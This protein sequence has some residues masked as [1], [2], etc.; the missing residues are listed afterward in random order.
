M[1]SF[2]I[3]TSCTILDKISRAGHHPWATPAGRLALDT[4]YKILRAREE[5]ER[6]N[7]EVRRITTHIRDEDKYLREKENSLVAI[8][9]R[10]AHQIAVHRMV[11][12]RFNSL[13][14]RRLRQIASLPGFTGTA[15]AGA[16]FEAYEPGPA[17]DD[18][19]ADAE[20]N[21]GDGNDNTLGTQEERDLQEEEEEAE[22]EE[23]LNNDLM[24]I[25]TVAVDG[26]SLSC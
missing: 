17:V 11:R 22:E 18:G 25:L 26:M 16:A 4:H 8:N 1:P 3:S 23:E 15:S 13:H 14:I 2:P 20:Q 10:L 7:L 24:D 19:E 12:G 9:P 5:L 21:V 6:L